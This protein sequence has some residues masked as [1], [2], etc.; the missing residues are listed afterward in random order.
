[1]AKEKEVRR[2][3][4]KLNLEFIK[5]EK[6]QTLYVKF[7][8]YGEKTWDEA[9]EETGEITPKTVRTLKF[10]TEKG[11]PVQMFENGGLK[12]LFDQL[13]PGKWYELES[14]GQEDITIT[15]KKTGKQEPGRVNKYGLYS[16]DAPSSGAQA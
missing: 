12:A 7:E 16:A 2:R 8:G 14:E 3:G 5:L 1:M 9:N 10:T 15:N 11:I 6:G 13:E 4:P